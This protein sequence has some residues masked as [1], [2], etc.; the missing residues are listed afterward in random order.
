MDKKG[1]KLN[2]REREL[3][4]KSITSSNLIYNYGKTAAIAFSAKNLKLTDIKE[5]LKKQKDLS[6]EF[7]DLIIL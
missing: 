5:I 4:T 1:E 3:K 2:K 7:F 6:D